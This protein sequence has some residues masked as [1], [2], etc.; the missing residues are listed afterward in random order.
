MQEHI[1][2]RKLPLTDI[3]RRALAD[4]FRFMRLQSKATLTTASR[5]DLE[6]LVGERA[7][8]MSDSEL[9]CHMKHQL[10]V[11]HFAVWHD[12]STVCGFGFIPVTCKEVYNN[13][14][15]YTNDEYKILTGQTVDVQV[16]VERPYIHLLAAGSSTASDHIAFTPDR[17]K[18]VKALETT[19]EAADGT[20]LKDILRFSHGDKVVQWIE[21]GYQAGGNYKCGACGVPTE[22]SIDSAHCNQLQYR[23]LSDA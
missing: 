12:H 11:R 23:S 20:H 17:V 18:C 8:H 7:C 13:L 15:H 14:V 3:R 6:G 4:Q 10:A 22:S 16:E 5:A 1:E 9:C 21:G 19:L 2:G